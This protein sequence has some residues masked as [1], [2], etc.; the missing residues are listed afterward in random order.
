MAAAEH[1]VVAPRLYGGRGRFLARR[2]GIALLTVFLAIVLI[3][4]AARALPG[5]PTTVLVGSTGVP[6]PEQRAEARTKY[7]LDEPIYV[8]FVRYLERLAHGDLGTSSYSG[9]AVGKTIRNRLPVTA[10]LALLSIAFAVLLG[11]AGGTLAAVMRGRKSDRAVT[12]LGMVGFSTPSFFLGLML[13]LVFAVSLRWLPAS[14]FVPF[15]EDPLENLKSMLLPVVSLGTA[16]AAVLM[17]AMRTAMI[18]ALQAK[19]VLAARG[20]GL[21]RSQVV[22]GHALRTS[23]LPLITISALQL[24]SVISSAVVIEQ[25]FLLPGLGS[26]AVEAVG[27]QDYAVIQAVALVAAVAYV[28][29]SLL[30]DVLYALADPRVGSGEGDG[31]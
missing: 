27:T 8:Q 20:R 16:M 7:G 31:L 15:D 12:T 22:F 21:T 3:F 29:L 17:L 30:A 23:L 24:G 6:T 25:L 9:E 10:E 18:H 11:V 19:Y 28:M 5:D 4:L 13:I 1:T 26:L 14:G 2:A